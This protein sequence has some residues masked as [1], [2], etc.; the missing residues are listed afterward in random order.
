MSHNDVIGQNYRKSANTANQKTL[1]IA[2][3]GRKGDD[4]RDETQGPLRI[5]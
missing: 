3:K 5:L 4:T 1:H 2:L